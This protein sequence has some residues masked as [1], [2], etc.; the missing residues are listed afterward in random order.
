MPETTIP[1]YANPDRYPVDLVAVVVSVH[2]RVPQVLVIAGEETGRDRLPAG[3]LAARHRTLEAGLRAWVGEQSQLDLGYVEQ[4]YTFG[5]LGRI[6]GDG[7]NTRHDLSIAYLALVRETRPSPQLSAIWR[8]WYA[9]FPWEDWREGRPALLDPLFAG[10]RA[11]A[12]GLEPA[13]RQ[14]AEERL[15]LAFGLSTGL[16][17]NERVLDRYE[18]LYEAG[19]A[20]EAGAEG[21]LDGRAMAYDHRRILATAVSRLRSKIQYRPVIFELMADSFTLLDLQETVE[22]LSGERLHKQN[23]RRLIEAQGLVEETGEQAKDRGGRPARLVR[24]RRSVLRERPAPGVR[25]PAP[26]RMTAD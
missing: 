11:W 10:L 9:F 7:R 14:R 15:E 19:L 26:R 18:L 2:R 17:S 22:A 8:D 4:L 5:D 3:P 25:L 20:R 16:W 24:F 21:G 12:A 13:A 1:S 23:F 6:V